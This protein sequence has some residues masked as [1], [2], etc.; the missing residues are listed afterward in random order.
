[1][2]V[3][4]RDSALACRNHSWIHLTP[5]GGIGIVGK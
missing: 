5:I 1:M 2:D 4:E 3:H